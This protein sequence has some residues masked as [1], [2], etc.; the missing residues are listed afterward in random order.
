MDN[1][2]TGSYYTP[3]NLVQAMVDYLKIS[4]SDISILEPSGGDGRVIKEI[5][6]ENFIRRVDIVELINSKIEFLNKEFEG[7]SN[8]HIINTDFLEYCN[9]CNIKYDLII[10]NPP[11]INKKF[12]TE[13]QIELSKKLCNEFSLHSKVANNIWVMFILG[14]LKL[15]NENGRILYI[16]P[17]EFLQVEYSKE[18]RN[19][20]EKKFTSIEVFVFEKEVFADIQQKV[21]LLSLSNISNKP[22]IEY[23]E[24]RGFD[25]VKPILKNKIYKNKPLDKWTNS[26]INDN[27]IEFINKLKEKCISIEEIGKMSP[28]VVTGANDFF[29]VDREFVKYIEEENYFEKIV[30]KSSLLKDIFILGENEYEK[31]DNENEKVHL[32]KLNNF[33]EL[34]SKVKD[35]IISG[36]KKE[37]NKRFKCSKR[38]TWYKLPGDRIGELIFFKRY[39]ILPRIIINELGCHTTD[40][41]YNISVDERYDT[42]SIAFCF[43][44]SLTLFLCEYNCRFYAGGVA[45]LT[46]NELRNVFI[47]YKTIHHSQIKK[48]NRMIG[49]KKDYNEIIKYV[50]KVV[51][52][53]IL[54]QD[55]L[56]KIRE[57]RQRYINRRINQKNIR[58]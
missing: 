17:F 34:S 29:I 7:N 52:E 25:L 45:E 54:D 2:K 16:L 24:I 55:D 50:D 19:M 32:L 35:Y 23:K 13:K 28:G 1:K 38:N 15:L 33:S 4:K 57:I 5:L 37:Y 20:L 56:N 44:N 9:S 39:D 43:Y 58:V 31:L 11:Y 40:A 27:E 30:P 18:L 46:P 3:Y 22:Y 41:G 14:A 51:F 48:L 49:E 47:P 8:V 42:K 21:C 10:G 53:N 12:L 36:E 26:I 6:R